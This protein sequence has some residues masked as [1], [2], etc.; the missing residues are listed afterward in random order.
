MSKGTEKKKKVLVDD[1]DF[2]FDFDG[3]DD[4]DKK[5]KPTES[6]RLFVEHPTQVAPQAWDIES[7][8]RDA[9]GRQF[10]VWPKKPKLTYLD[11][12]IT[13]QLG[14][15]G[16]SSETKTTV[17][18]L[19]GKKTRGKELPQEGDKLQLQPMQGGTT[20]T[21]HVKFALLA[22]KP[23]PNARS[24]LLVIGEVQG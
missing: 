12:F 13:D 14:S 19:V 2:D 21:V 7:D 5:V 6:I 11:S 15:L 10:S 23:Y 17:A 18:V 24:T 8:Y 3:G 4:K 1:L 9:Q 16:Y 22:G 20:R